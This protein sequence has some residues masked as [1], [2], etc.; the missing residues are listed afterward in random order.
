MSTPNTGL[1]LTTLRSGVACVSDW[2]RQ[3]PQKWP[4]EQFCGAWYVLSV[5][6][7]PPR[8]GS[9]TPPSACTR[10]QGSLS[11]SPWPPPTSSP[12]TRTY[13]PGHLIPMGSSCTR[14]SRPGFSTERT[15]L[16][17]LGASAAFIRSFSMRPFVPRAELSPSPRG[18]PG[19]RSGST[20]TRPCEGGSTGPIPRRER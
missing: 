16:T 11:P 4:S 18:Q 1:E 15:A 9:G 6:Q 12:A 5:V 17:V 8:P 3:V 13:L 14:P 19:H 10:E 20:H 2:A 7:P